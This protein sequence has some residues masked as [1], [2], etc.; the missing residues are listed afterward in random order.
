[1]FDQFKLI[2]KKLFEEG[3]VTSHSGSLSVRDG[4]KI[5]I[6]KKDTML[7][8]IKENDLIEVPLDGEYDK[9]AASD[10]LVHRAIYAGTDARSIIH[11]Y[12]SYG[13]ASS[14]QEEKI[15][16]QDAEGK[17]SLRSI[18]VIRVRDL[19]SNDEIIKFLVPAIK[20]GYPGCLV[21]GQGSYAIGLSL[22]AAYR[23]TSILEFSSKIAL[24]TKAPVV[25]ESKR[26]DRKPH[27]R[28]AIPPSIGVMDRTFRDRPK[29]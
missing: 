23:L 12:P 9:T 26:E 27:Y 4:D 17:S 25:T 14:M 21:R 29:R 1:M 18:P 8:E 11:A 2:G 7:S 13:I 28:S 20:S 3:L 24:L 16:P 15:I 5:I 10:V 6:T 19:N 22:E